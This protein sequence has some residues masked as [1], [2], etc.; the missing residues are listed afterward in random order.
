MPDIS[1]AATRNVIW[2]ALNMTSADFLIRATP[3]RDILV[4][5]VVRFHSPTTEEDFIKAGNQRYAPRDD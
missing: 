2:T 3:L 1:D 5:H 4:E